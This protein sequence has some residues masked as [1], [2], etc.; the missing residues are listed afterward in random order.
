MAESTT[1]ESSEREGLEWLRDR[2][3]SLM[4]E[5][6]ALTAGVPTQLGRDDVEEII[7]RVDWLRRKAIDAGWNV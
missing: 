3:N 5:L 2:H 1:L 7:K 4:V 6:E